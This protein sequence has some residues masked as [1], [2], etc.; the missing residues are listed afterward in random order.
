MVVKDKWTCL[1][2]HCLR[3]LGEP[4]YSYRIV[5][6]ELVGPFA[7]Q[8]EFHA[9]IYLTHGDISPNNILVDDS[10]RHVSL[11]DFGCAAWMPEYWELTY[12]IYGRQLYP[13][14]VKAFTH[15]FP[16]YK[17]ELAVEMEQRKYISLW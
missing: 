8:E 5:H 4:F 7:L 14:W 9:S 17:E 10:Y 3:F 13:G 11:V 15:M 12:P 1:F 6:E 2:S 16:Q